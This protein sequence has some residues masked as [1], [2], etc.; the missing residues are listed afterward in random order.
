MCWDSSTIPVRGRPAR[1]VRA[2][3]APSSVWSGGIRMSMT[4]RSGSVASTTATSEGAS[5]ALAT[6]S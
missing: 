5:A 4:A 6:T 2:A 3:R 1:T